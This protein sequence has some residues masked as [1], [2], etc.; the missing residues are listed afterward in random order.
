VLT[1]RCGV[2]AVSAG[3]Y[4]TRSMRVGNRRRERN[5][6]GNSDSGNRCWA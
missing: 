6:H 3:D 4:P 5:T 1:E 2:R